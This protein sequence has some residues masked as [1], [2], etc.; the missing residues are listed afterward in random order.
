MVFGTA[1]LLVWR[2]HYI[3]PLI[4]LTLCLLLLH[5]SPEPTS[6]APGPGPAKPS[7]DPALS[8]VIKAAETGLP[9]HQYNDISIF[10]NN[11]GACVESIMECRRLWQQAVAHKFSMCAALGF[12]DLALIYFSAWQGLLLRMALTS[13]FAF[14]L[15]KH[16]CVARV[17]RALYIY[18]SKDATL[19]SGCFGLGVTLEPLE[20]PHRGSAVARMGTCH[21]TPNATAQ[22]SNSSPSATSNTSNSS[23]V[24]PSMHI[25]EETSWSEPTWC[26]H[27]GGFLWGVYRQ[28]WTC[29][30]CGVV[31][32]HA[33]AAEN[34]L[35]FCPKSKSK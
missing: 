25:L 33:C 17:M 1:I 8:K 5:S 9:T 26:K 18:K 3:L 2:P 10:Q 7:R 11:L 13:A 20:L 6:G 27:C 24:K 21:L 23:A 32:C 30:D 19:S 14:L 22:L 28:G 34:H 15:A 31:L 35:D 16:S 12:V 4:L 29:R